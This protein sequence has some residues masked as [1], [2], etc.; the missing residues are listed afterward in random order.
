M[1]PPGPAS[2]QEAAPGAG[3][4][5]EGIELRLQEMAAGLL[6]IHSSLL[7]PRQP[8][9]RLGFDSIMVVELRAN[10]ESSLG[11]TLPMRMLLDAP[12]VRQLASRITEHLG[13][14]G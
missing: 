10:L 5:R 12:S 8:L 2:G 14:P 13:A 6:R 11:V 9:S 1:A 7:D 3:D 4:P